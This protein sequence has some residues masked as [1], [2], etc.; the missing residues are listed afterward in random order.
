MAPRVLVVVPR[1]DIGGAEIH[2]S[3]VLPKLR[4]S[5]LDVSLLALSRGGR[6]EPALIESGVPVYGPRVD[7][8]RAMRSLQAALALRGESRRLHPDIVHF[9][10]A[11]AYL[12][13]SLAIA[14]VREIKRVMSRRSL[15]DYQRKHPFLSRMERRLHRST[16][17]LLANSSAVAG[18]LI[19]ECGNRDKVGLIHSGLDI[20][21]AVSPDERLA[22]RREL[23]I[24]DDARVLITVGNLFRYKGHQDLLDALALSQVRI[25]KPWR[26]VLV[27]R[28]EGAG[29]ELRKQAA[30]S[31]LAPN[32]M[33]LGERFN[34]RALLPSADIG[35]LPSHEEGFSNSLVEKM[36]HGLPVI[37]TRVGGNI[38]AIVDRQCGLLVPARD[39]A[40]LATAILELCDDPGLRDRLG[41]AARKR[42]QDHFSLDRCAQRY[43]N[44]YRRILDRDRG[45]VQDIIDRP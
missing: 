43:L 12:L 39:P 40:A 27:G 11:E 16:D 32:L 4:A 35:I 33:W 37:A 5:G 19:E 31:G 25:A 6:L 26:L 36:A 18:Q 17:V 38:D 22:L 29:E 14:G 7:G 44:L 2:L 15:S 1:L 24:P 10:L 30:A 20:P 9:F 21:P 28:D 23:G 8:S 42:A 41:A 13:G 34:A 45:P 3:R